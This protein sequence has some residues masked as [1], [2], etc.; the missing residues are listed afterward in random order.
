MSQITC[1]TKK[2]IEDHVKDLFSLRVTHGPDWPDAGVE[3]HSLEERSQLR[4]GLALQLGP[5]H[6]ADEVAV[7]QLNEGGDQVVLG[8]LQ[9]WVLVDNL[10][11]EDKC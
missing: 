5:F 6:Q 1:P 4:F 8:H 10:S 9:H 11:N 7:E 2:L 3:E